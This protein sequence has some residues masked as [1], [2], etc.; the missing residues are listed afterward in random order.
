MSYKKRQISRRKREWH[1]QH[2]V[3]EKSPI[4]YKVQQ[5]VRLRPDWPRPPKPV[6]LE[7]FVPDLPEIFVATAKAAAWHDPTIFAPGPIEVHVRPYRR[8]RLVGLP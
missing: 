7:R 6:P 2:H 3:I 1:A 8:D 4:I 5:S